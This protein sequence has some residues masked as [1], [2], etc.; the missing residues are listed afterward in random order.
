MKIRKDIANKDSIISKNVDTSNTSDFYA[1]W[2]EK[3]GKPQD[4]TMPADKFMERMKEMID[5]E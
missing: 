4:R 5:F 3:F 2:Y 1:R